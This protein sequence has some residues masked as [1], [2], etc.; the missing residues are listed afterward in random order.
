MLHDTIRRL[1]EEHN[2]TREEVAEKL[3]L[4][5]RTYARIETGE[6][7]LDWERIRS[8]AELYNMGPE[9]LV[10]RDQGQ[11]TQHFN[12]E[13]G[14]NGNINHGQAFYCTIYSGQKELYDQLIAQ[15]R[16]ENQRL[17]KEMERIRE[18][19]AFL[20]EELIRARRGES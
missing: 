11:V 14:N 12:G 10:A 16:D 3:N 1:R 8:I 18:D 20:R 9:E 15:V 7:R 6:T 19:M 13:S 5:L 17:Q 2:L 4:A